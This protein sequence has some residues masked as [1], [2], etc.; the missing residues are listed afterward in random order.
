[1]DCILQF[2]YLFYIITQ[3]LCSIFRIST[4]IYNVY[5]QFTLTVGDRGNKELFNDLSVTIYVDRDKQNPI[6]DQADYYFTIPESRRVDSVVG[7]IRA[8]DRDLR[9]LVNILGTF[10]MNSINQFLNHL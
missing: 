7:E 8:T 1:M 6:F 4:L 2:N 10:L 3:M 5:L 9:P